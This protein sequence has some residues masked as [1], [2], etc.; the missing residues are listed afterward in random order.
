[1]QVGMIGLG[2]MGANM[3]RRLMRNGHDVVG[4]DLN[5]EAVAELASDGGDAAESLADLV[6]QLEGPRTV[7]MMVPAGDAVDATMDDLLPLLD[8]G[9]RLIDGGN[10]RY[11][12]TLRR[13]GRA[14]QVGVHYVDVGT[15]GGVWGLDEGYSMM[16]GGPDDAV[17]A[18][19]PIFESLAP[20]PEKGWGHVGKAGAGH[21]VKMVHNG[22]EYGV[23]QAYAEGFHIMNAK[24]EF[25]LDLHQVAEIWRFG[26]VIRSWL[27]DLAARALDEDQDLADV[28]AWVDDSGEGR[29]T[30]QEAIDLDVPAPVIT[31]ALIQRLQSRQDATYA[32][33]LLAALRNQFGGHDVK[34]AE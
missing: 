17:N 27:L 11:T 1:M 8:E 16:V 23:M 30:V 26:S 5:Q 34:E 18:L 21:F 15:S 20:G 28:A 12:D 22:I 33:R 24:D 9:D 2:K 25:D 13:A 3:S 31:D 4:F 6:D 14:Q 7:W 32:H 10:T 19:R 29:W